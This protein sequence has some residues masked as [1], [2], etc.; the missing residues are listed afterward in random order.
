MEEAEC[1]HQRVTQSLLARVS[2]HV[3]GRTVRD[4]GKKG[5]SSLHGLGQEA[6]GVV[7][8]TVPPCLGSEAMWQQIWGILISKGQRGQLDW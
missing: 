4:K 6:E 7:G 5:C 2:H 1:F 3:R 8:H